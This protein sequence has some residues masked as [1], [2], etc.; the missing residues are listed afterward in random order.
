MY[1]TF[2]LF[3]DQEL[4][5]PTSYHG[6]NHYFQNAKDRMDRTFDLIRARMEGAAVLDI[7]ASPFYLLDRALEAGATQAEGI[8]FAHDLHPLKDRGAIFSAHGR[9]GIH[10]LDI[11]NQ[12]LPFADNSFDVVSA[13]EILEHL[14]HFPALLGA[15]IRR[16]LKPGGQLLLTVPNA[17]SVGN[18]L[19]L[20]AGR[21]IFMKYR[22]DSTGRH[23]HEYTMSQLSAMARYIGATPAREGY[24]PSP[25]SDKKM[26]RPLYRIIAAT[27]FIRR[28]SPI[29]YV[30]A[31]MPQSKPLGPP[32]A[33]PS[34]LYAEDRSIEE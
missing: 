2:Q 3:L 6:R 22:S 19:K 26:L 14:E 5:R 30:L 9:I 4:T 32:G 20:I 33:P 34:E 12:P 10:H 8:Y 23:K 17:G 24:F 29:L 27:P 31:N 18:I 15:E 13:C 21:N 16:V 7:G 25:T 28:Y 11:E 1:D